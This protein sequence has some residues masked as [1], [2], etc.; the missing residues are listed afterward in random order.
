MKLTKKQ[1]KIKT[2][3]NK[4]TKN[5]RKILFPKLITSVSFQKDLNPQ[6]VE[7]K[8]IGR[9]LYKNCKVK[10]M[11]VLG[12]YMWHLS[13]TTKLSEFMKCNT[14]ILKNGDFLRTIE[15]SI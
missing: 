11:W 1:N 2:K 5:F 7:N 15:R 14:V 6:T 3:T 9:N 8:E 13:L 4:Q 12:F 10:L